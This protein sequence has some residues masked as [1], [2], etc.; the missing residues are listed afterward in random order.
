MSFL[1]RVTNGGGHINR[2]YA[3]GRGRMDLMV[4][5]AGKCHIIEM[6]IIH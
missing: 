5:Y 6:K 2:E 4:E 3:A 1:Q